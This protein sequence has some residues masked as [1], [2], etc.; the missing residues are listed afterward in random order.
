MWSLS[1]CS[2]GIARNRRQRD[3]PQQSQGRRRSWPLAYD[4]HAILEGENAVIR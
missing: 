2:G 1:G 3:A 4:A